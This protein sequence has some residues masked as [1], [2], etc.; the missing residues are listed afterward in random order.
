MICVRALLKVSANYR[1]GPLQRD[2]TQERGP[3]K[4]RQ[5]FYAQLNLWEE[6]ALE[7]DEVSLNYAASR[8][9]GEAFWRTITS[10]YKEGVPFLVPIDYIA[11]Y[12]DLGRQAPPDGQR[13]SL[14]TTVISRKYVASKSESLAPWLYSHR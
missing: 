8:D 13:Y 4:D 12:K 6:V 7:L 10:K 9:A 1:E 11:K 5:K 3:V 2:L 14:S